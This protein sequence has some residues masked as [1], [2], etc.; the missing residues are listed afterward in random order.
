MVVEMS[1]TISMAEPHERIV[2]LLIDALSLGY[3]FNHM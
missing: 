2:S 3:S 1:T